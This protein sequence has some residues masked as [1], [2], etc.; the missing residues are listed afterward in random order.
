MLFRSHL[1]S[2]CKIGKTDSE[3]KTRFFRGSWEFIFFI[4]YIYILYFFCF[5]FFEISLK[6]DK[7]LLHL[8]LKGYAFTLLF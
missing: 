3:R 4:I 5:L 1:R 8:S 2:E 6:A 7:L